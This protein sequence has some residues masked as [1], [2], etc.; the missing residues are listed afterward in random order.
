MKFNAF[1]KTEIEQYTAEIKEKWGST[2]AYE[3]YETKIKGKSDNELKETTDQL[4][5]LF[6]EIGSLKHSL[7]TEKIVQNKIKTLQDFITKNYYTCTNEILEGLSQMYVY[8]E[9]MKHNIDKTGGDGTAEFVK[10]AI[11]IYCSNEENS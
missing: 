6:A 2:K 11:F 1:S 9:R 3:E 5:N 10:Q 4:M 8:D 7:P